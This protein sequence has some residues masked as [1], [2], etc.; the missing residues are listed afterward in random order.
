MSILG[1]RLLIK[2]L[3][4]LNEEKKIRRNNLKNWIKHLSISGLIKNQMS[5]IIEIK[6]P[7]LAVLNYKKSKD[8]N[9][10]F[11]SLLNAKIPVSTWPDLPP[12]VL[13]DHQKQE[14]AISLRNCRIY[15][16]VHKSITA[17]SIES[18][19]G[20]INILTN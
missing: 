7:Y 11:A 6:T 17:K 18:A 5:K 13:L 20:R 10:A 15:L 9:K 14:V 1:K 8:A 3:N 2:L 16:P 19:V 12:E 4:N